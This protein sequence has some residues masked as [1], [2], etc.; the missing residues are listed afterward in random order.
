MHVSALLHFAFCVNGR[1]EFRLLQYSFQF[2]NGF[3]HL[4]HT[5]IKYVLWPLFVDYP[6]VQW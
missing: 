1:E 4:A 2:N 3:I 6:P 5:D